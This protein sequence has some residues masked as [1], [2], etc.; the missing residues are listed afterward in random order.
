MLA[1]Y[2]KE[3][4]SYFI[5]P[6]GYV[7]LG[8]YL[9]F[10]ALL[11][12]YTTI[13]SSSYN[14]TTYFTMMVFVL[15]V[16]IPILTMRSFAEER[17]MKTEQLL[18][19]SPVS[20]TSMVLGKFLSVLTVAG[21]SFLVSCINLLPLAISGAAARGGES[22]SMRHIGLVPSKVIGCIIGIVLISCV[23]VAIGL[24]ISS[25]TENQ[26]AAAVMTIGVI[27]VMVVISFLNMIGS[28][29]DGTRLITSTFL[30]G[31]IDWISVLSRF[32]SFSAGKIALADV[33]YYVSLA[34]IFLLLTVRVYDKRRYS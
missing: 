12:A 24:F 2:K 16:F 18:L 5:N 17:K 23:F 3:F 21:G 11:C 10:S 28:D 34:F 14:T 22:Y 27:M 30:R 31:I 9:T 25:L 13:Q 8:V 32:S 29:S 1:I 26:L 15:A 4:R 20:V 7:F 19:T 33:L 6:I